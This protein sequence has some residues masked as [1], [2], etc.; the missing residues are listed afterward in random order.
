MKH[1]TKIAI[2]LYSSMLIFAQAIP[3]SAT[4]S[5]LPAP[6]LHF[7]GLDFVTFEP[8]RK[9]GVI[10]YTIGENAQ[11][12]TAKRYVEPFQLN[13]YETTY[14]LWYQVRLWAED[15]GYYFEHKGKEGSAGAVSKAPSP[16][17][18]NEPVTNISWYD[19]I[20]WCNALSEKEGLT[21]C[22]TYNGHVL[23]DSSDTIAC[24]LATCA[25]KSAGYRLPTEAEWEYAAR[26]TPYGMQRGDLASGQTERRDKKDILIPEES[27]SWIY[28]NAQSTHIVGTAGRDAP[29]ENTVPQAGS[30]KANGAG[31][32]DM[33]G[34]VLELCW[35][36]FA[37]YEDVPFGSRATGPRFAE[38][39]VLRGGSFSEETPFYYAG[40]RYAYDPNEAYTFI[41]F[42]LCR[43][44]K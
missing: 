43:T 21:P 38:A 14:R 13:R 16:L 23:R 27:V 1:G 4:E 35:D 36:W 18:E 22:Y 10:E 34:N 24:D 25:W 20:V 41:G 15:H 26:K 7:T 17:K 28:Q 37:D 30:G 29:L 12:Y 5:S 31:L 19:A 2:L 32:F 44:V 6:E 3:A 33:S 11:T 39:R 40:D 8:E 9:K 42:R